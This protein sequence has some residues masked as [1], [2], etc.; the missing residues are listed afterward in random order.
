M[1]Y[2]IE[3]ED[4][5]PAHIDPSTLTLCSPYV[6]M[7]YALHYGSMPSYWEPGEAGYAEQDGPL[8]TQ[9]A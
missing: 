2:T 4:E 9:C 1:R 3:L 6:A 5:V 8:P 7:E